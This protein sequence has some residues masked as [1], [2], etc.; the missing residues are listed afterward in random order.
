M[1]ICDGGKE[2]KSQRPS[3]NVAIIFHD[4]N[5]YSGATRS[6]IDIIDTWIKRNVNYRIFAVFPEKTG[7]AIDY[8]SKRNVEVIYCR[9]GGIVYGKSDNKLATAIRI[10]K[11]FFK[12]M[13]SL[14]NTIFILGKKFNKNKIDIVYTNT[15][16]IYVGA[17]I[18]KYN[19]IP[20]IWHFREFGG[21]DQESFRLFG[22]KKFINFV[23]Q[24]SDKVICISNAL[25]SKYKGCF[26]KDLVEI[27]YDDISDNYINFNKKSLDEGRQLQILMVGRICEGKG[28]KQVIEAVNY[29]VNKGLN[30]KLTIVG[31]AEGKYYELLTEIVQSHH[32]ENHIIFCGQLNKLKDIR[33]NSDIGIIASKSEA[34]GRVTIEGMLSCM[35]MICANTGSSIELIDNDKN[36]LLYV[37][38]DV[39]DLAEKV[40]YI[41]FNRNKIDEI[42]IN[43]YK[44]ALKFT[45]GNCADKIA[46]IMS[47]ILQ[48]TLN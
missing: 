46:S 7:S 34:F 23:E 6:M 25:A 38:N 42:G 44:Y 9:Y 26:N 24:Y 10:V 2:V 21:E 36:G 47:D 43:A 45:Q 30:I 15:S 32:A 17:W 33:K 29:L 3:K 14:I 1:K 40:E 8:L 18:K 19:G 39:N 11:C 28:Q 12:Y 4:S 35:A 27:V 31:N 22:E 48:D 13:I 37:F 20:H 41:Y 5:Y 16:T